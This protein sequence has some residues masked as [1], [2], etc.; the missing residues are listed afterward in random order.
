MG[1]TKE[2]IV[3]PV[4]EIKERHKRL[5]VQ[6]VGGLPGTPYDSGLASNTVTVSVS[7]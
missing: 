1:R 4:F 3:L 6:L 2:R 5:K 7:R